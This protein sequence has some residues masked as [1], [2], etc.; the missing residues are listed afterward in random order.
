M[1][2]PR[3]VVALANSVWQSAILVG[4]TVTLLRIMSRTSANLRYAVWLATLAVCVLLPVVDYGFA[5][6]LSEPAVAASRPSNLPGTVTQTGEAQYVLTPSAAQTSATHVFTVSAGANRALEIPTWLKPAA[7]AAFFARATSRASKMLFWSWIVVADVLLARI[8]LQL[9]SLVRAKQRIEVID[10]FDWISQ[11]PGVR[12]RRYSVGISDSVDIPCLLGLTQPLIAIPRAIATELSS[13]DLRR[14][15]LHESAHVRRYDDWFN[16]FEQCVMSLLFFNPALYYATR[17]LHLEREIACDDQVVATDERL[18]YAECLS[19]LAGRTR[20]RSASFVPSF[21]SGRRELLIRIEELLDR[22]HVAHAR[23]GIVPY[24]V[25]AVLGVVALVLGQ[26]GI[27]VLA[28]PTQ[29]PAPASTQQPPPNVA[30]SSSPHVEPAPNVV[31]APHV[32]QTRETIMVRVVEK[33]ES[34][35]VSSRVRVRQG[36]E[37]STQAV[38][39]SETFV[40]NGKA[41]AVASVVAPV[42]VSQETA[43]TRVA[44]APPC[45]PVPAVAPGTGHHVMMIDSNIKVI[46]CMKSL[47]H[48]HVRARMTD[49]D[50]KALKAAGCTVSNPIDIQKVRMDSLH[51]IDMNAIHAEVE[52]AMAE[53]QR[54]MQSMPRDGFPQLDAA[55]RAL[56]ESQAQVGVAEATRRASELRREMTEMR[57]EWAI[58]PPMKIHVLMPK[59]EMPAIDMIDFDT[60]LP[61]LPV[62]EITDMRR[63]GVTGAYI[64]SLSGVGYSGLSAADYIRLHDHGVTAESVERLRHAHS[65]TKLSVDDLIRLQH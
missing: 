8:L 51:A 10:T 61:Q 13:N 59:I 4:F 25:A 20:V 47:P 58:S 18:F 64:A 56:A 60:T 27:P 19:V 12:R 65:G 38:T 17:A 3:I 43:A 45:I 36:A 57:H 50:I 54:S 1:I 24:A 23:L 53:M 55:A 9:V 42:A 30:P 33:P 11:R 15:V 26:T 39:E 46:M 2:E 63:H 62:K 28:A 22:K 6:H 16:L 7:W 14:I 5:R 37:S 35:R 32:I 44:P 21:F 29:A 40:V 41:C 52:H 31:R 49:A 34:S 48:V